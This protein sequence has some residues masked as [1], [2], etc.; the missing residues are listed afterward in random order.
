VGIEMRQRLQ[1]YVA[2]RVDDATLAL[3]QTAERREVNE[4]T[5]AA[6][7][8][9][10]ALA[11][12]AAEVDSNE[13]PTGLFIRALNEAIDSFG[14]RESGLRRQAPALVMVVLFGSFVM[15]AVAVGFSAGVSGHRP[16]GMAY[17]LIGLLVVLAFIIIDL[18]RPRRGLIQVDKTILLELKSTIDSQEALLRKER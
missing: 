17:M 9:I 3:A 10:W 11:R 18:E 15:T 4:K 12:R 16:S 13:V 14:R 5:N 2:L 8:A 1:D 6:V 7:D